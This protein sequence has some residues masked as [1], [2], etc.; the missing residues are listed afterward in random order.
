MLCFKFGKTTASTSYYTQKNQQTVTIE[1]KIKT[2]HDKNRL[3][4]FMTMNPALQKITE[5]ILWTG[6]KT[7]SISEATGKNKPW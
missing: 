1:G 2:W 7:N 6:E 5:G 4:E 3:Q